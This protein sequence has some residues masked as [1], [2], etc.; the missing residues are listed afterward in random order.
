MK[1]REQWKVI[2]R[3]DESK[4][5]PFLIFLVDLY[6]RWQDECEYEDIEDYLDAIKRHVP[7]AIEITEEPFGFKT[8]CDD[9]ILA[10]WIHDDGEQIKLRGE[11]TRGGE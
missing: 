10:V 2:T 1:A 9:G 4:T 7:A 5:T 11:I 3:E 8:K 6:D